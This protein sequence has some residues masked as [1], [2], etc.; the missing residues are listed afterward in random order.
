MEDYT[1]GTSRKAYFVMTGYNDIRSYGTNVYNKIKRCYQ[2]VVYNQILK[3]WKAGSEYSALSSPG[4]WN[5]T[6]FK[7]PQDKTYYKVGSYFDAFSGSAVAGKWIEYTF[8]GDGVVLSMR[9]SRTFD[10][11]YTWPGIVN[12]HVDGN[13]VD[14]VDLLINDGSAFWGYEQPTPNLM[15]LYKGFGAGAHTIRI[16]TTA[17]VRN[18]GFWID[19]I[20]EILD[21]DVD[22][23]PVLMFDIPK[24]TVS[25]YTIQAGFDQANDTIIQDMNDILK[26]EVK[27]EVDSLYPS[28]FYNTPTNDYYLRSGDVDPDQIH[29]NAIGHDHL[30]DAAV[31][32]IDG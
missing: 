17:T 32:V 14:T 1:F 27:A 2:N 29:P 30:E 23:T 9:T 20:G 24:M 12:I 11:S 31:A 21:S 19:G 13:L 18:S 15:K 5:T 25:G 10:P 28:S 16:T 26:N 3:N 7:Y 6:F 4:H 8:T 22:V